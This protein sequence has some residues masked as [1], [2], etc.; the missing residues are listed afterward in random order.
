MSKS[1]SDA[2]IPFSPQKKEVSVEVARK[3]GSSSLEKLEKTPEFTKYSTLVYRVIPP[4]SNGRLDHDKR[5][6]SIIP[7]GAK[8][9]VM[10]NTNAAHYA[11]Y[12]GDGKLRDS[13]SE[14]LFNSATGWCEYY[15]KLYDPAHKGAISGPLETAVAIID[16]QKVC[17]VR[18][19]FFDYFHLEHII[20]QEKQLQWVIPQ[21]IPKGVVECIS[22]PPNPDSSPRRIYLDDF[23]DEDEEDEEPITPSTSVTSCT[24][25]VKKRRR[26]AKK[27]KASPFFAD[28]IDHVLQE[29]DEFGGTILLPVAYTVFPV[30][31]KSSQK[32]GGWGS[33]DVCA[34]QRLRIY[35]TF[36]GAH[37][38]KCRMCLMRDV[39]YGINNRDCSHIVP[40]NQGGNN[41][42][43]FNRTDVCSTCNQRSKEKNGNFFDMLCTTQKEKILFFAEGLRRLYF[44]GEA[45]LNY[46][47]DGRE[48]FIRTVYGDST[49]PGGIQN[50]DVFLL[51][52]Q[53]DKISPLQQWERNPFLNAVHISMQ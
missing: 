19:K 42:A 47:F 34:E 48:D 33:D 36:N 15:A 6:Q 9:V 10:K 37:S 1:F 39:D 29:K 26:S 35:E 30:Q 8:L 32:T 44:M 45:Q 38:N 23:D 51:L 13:D 50:G 31:T 27:V 49:V 28:G 41:T 11:T 46:T 14:T 53:L 24:A 3:D 2:L 25:E 5:W 40:R 18:L 7:W 4:T 52:Q 22:N 20:G 16:A 17:H 21:A 43:T 12:E